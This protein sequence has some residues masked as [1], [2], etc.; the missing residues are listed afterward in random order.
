MISSYL[1][2]KIRSLKGKVEDNY[3]WHI[4]SGTIGGSNL[5]SNYLSTTIDKMDQLPEYLARVRGIHSITKLDFEITF[6]VN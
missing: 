5:N 2:S 3:G 1:S 4:A 6:S